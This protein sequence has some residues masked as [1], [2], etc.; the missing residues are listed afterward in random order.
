MGNTPP[1]P[2]HL[3]PIIMYR[4]HS[5]EIIMSSIW[6]KLDFAQ[7]IVDIVLEFK[8]GMELWEKLEEDYAIG[9]Y[10]IMPLESIHWN[11]DALFCM[12][13]ARPDVETFERN[14]FYSLECNFRLWAEV[15][16]NPIEDE[17]RLDEPSSWMSERRIVDQRVLESCIVASLD[18]L[19]QQISD[20]TGFERGLAVPT[21][22]EWL[23]VYEYE[24]VAC[25][26][27][28]DLAEDCIFKVVFKRVMEYYRLPSSE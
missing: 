7:A 28:M 8:G 1:H 16:D 21:I 23:E 17:E 10:S 24:E 19:S 13:F 25:E 26:R 3:Y 27:Y 14:I 5:R 15:A 20:H 18:R 2:P 22:Y 6:I 4:R 12:F 9:S 11:Y